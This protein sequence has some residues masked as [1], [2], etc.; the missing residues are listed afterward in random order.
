HL[1]VHPGQ[2]EDA[3]IEIVRILD[4]AGADL[5]RTTID[6]I[7]RAVREP[8][9]RIELAKTGC[10]LEYDLFGREG[11]YPIHVR[12]IDLPND[13]HRINE[14]MELIDKGYLNQILISQDIWNKTQRCTYGGW[15]YAHIMHNTLPVM[16][17]KGM[18]DEQ[19]HTIMVDNP[20]RAFAFV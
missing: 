17:L 6:H 20:R 2:A 3:A 14:I 19:I 10:Y 4:K 1:N 16:R 13:A 5:S 7:D 18:T 8:E 15:G 9:N 11:Y 12:L